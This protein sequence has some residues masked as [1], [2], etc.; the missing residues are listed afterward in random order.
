MK[1]NKFLT[2][3]LS[4]LL[5]ITGCST[6]QFDEYTYS[7]DAPIKEDILPDFINCDGMVVDGE[8]EECYGDSVTRLYY[9]NKENHSIYVDNYMY[10]GE[11]GIHCFVEVHDDLISYVGTRAVYYNSSVELFFN[12]WNKNYIDGDTL[13][14]RI[15]AGE[16]FTKL[17]GLKNKSTYTSSYFDGVFKVKLLGEFFKPGGEGFNVEVFI[18]WYELGIESVDQ[19]D[20]LMYMVAYNAVHE[21]SGDSSI[22]S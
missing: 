14:Y 18:P 20:G 4:S 19:V 5:L 13:Q 7:N 10:F 16:S 22:A 17:V 11:T 12:N 6:Y 2:I 21:T 1:M 9:K 8:K 3:L 15:S